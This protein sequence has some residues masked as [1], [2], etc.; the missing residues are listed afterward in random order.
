M[1]NGYGEKHEE[2]EE[3]SSISSERPDLGGIPLLV[4]APLSWGAKR[5]SAGHRLAPWAASRSY[6]DGTEV[7]E[8]A[9][10]AFPP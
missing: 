7:E 8:K 2:A 5:L 6:V 9:P 3:I 10:A 4:L 1:R